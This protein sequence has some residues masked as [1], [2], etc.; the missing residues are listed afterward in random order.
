MGT[1]AAGHLWQICPSLVPIFCEF[2]RSSSSNSI[3][4]LLLCL[5]PKPYLAGYHS[6]DAPSRA[7]RKQR[8]YPYSFCCSPRSNPPSLILR[9]VGETRSGLPFQFDP[10]PNGSSTFFL[11]TYPFIQAS[12]TSR[13]FLESHQCSR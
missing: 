8:V 6:W 7:T 3:S 12:N 1:N 4:H 5:S 13:H 11:P 10:I 9:S 2:H